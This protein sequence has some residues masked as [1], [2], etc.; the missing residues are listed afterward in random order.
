MQKFQFAKADSILAK[1]NRDFKGLNISELDAV[2][3]I[4]EALGFMKIVT[5]SE[6]AVAFYE[7]KNYH[8]EIPFGMHYIT[9]IARNNDWEGEQ[10][11]QLCVIDTIDSLTGECDFEDNRCIDNLVNAHTDCQGK[12]I[13]DY[14]PAYYRPFFDLQYEYLGWAHSRTRQSKY[15]TVT[16]ANHTFFNTLVCKEEGMEDLYTDGCRGD[17]YTIAGDSLRFN[18]ESGFVAIAY[19]R[20]MLDKDTGYPMIPDDESARA[21]ITYYLGWKFKEQECWN[22]REGSCQLADRAEQHWLKYVKQFKNKA[23]MPTGVD[24]H[25]RLANQGNYLIPPRNR[26]FGFF[27]N[28]GSPEKRRFNTPN[29]RTYY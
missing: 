23:K 4:G 3:W 19:T 20:T 10:S 28:L 13:G 6:H 25:Q 22:H 26:T 21:A 15:S 24:Q 17:E 8:T 14:E 7:V 5:A 11:N 12:L 29:R 16:L 18:F 2:E 9:Q 1:F 27:G